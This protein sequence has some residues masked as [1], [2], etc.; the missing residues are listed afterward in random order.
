MYLPHWR[1]FVK[2]Q[3]ERNYSGAAG[4]MLAHSMRRR[5]GALQID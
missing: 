4:G 2:G 5:R 3:N 1:F